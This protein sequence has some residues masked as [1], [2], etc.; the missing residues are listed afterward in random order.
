[1]H[2][3]KVEVVDGLAVARPNRIEADLG[4]KIQFI[5]DEEAWRVVFSPWPFKEAERQVKT[6]QELTF[7][8]EG[9]FQYSCFVT[10]KGKDQREVSGSGGTGNVPRPK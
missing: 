2:Q 8:K 6:S 7:G 4:D 5:S 10:P 1:M 3:V 9:P